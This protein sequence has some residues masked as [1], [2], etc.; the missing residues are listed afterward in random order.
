[1]RSL[2]WVVLLFTVFS[3]V[4][5]SLA[6]Q[7]PPPAVPKLIDDSD[8]LPLPAGM[9][10]EAV[11][12]STPAKLLPC[13]ADDGVSGVADRRPGNPE[14]PLHLYVGRCYAPNG[15]LFFGECVSLPPSCIFG[16]NA[17]KCQSG[18]RAIRPGRL[19]CSGTLHPEVDLARTCTF[20][21]SR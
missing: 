13:A 1:M 7:A 14:Q 2:T 21:L 4:A 11:A 19:N 17:A 15:I 8:P 20:Y 12:E 6:Q 9:T 16:R 18:R 10:T 5:V 3:L